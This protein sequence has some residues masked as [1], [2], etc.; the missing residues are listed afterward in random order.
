MAFGAIRGIMWKKWKKSK[1]SE[2]H[3]HATVAPMPGTHALEV[4]DQAVIGS[5][6]SIKG[7]LIGEEDLSIEGRLE[8]K[9]ELWHHRLTIEKS[10]RI[11]G[12]IHGKVIT[13][14][15]VVEGNLYAEEQLI[16]CQSA[17]IRGNLVSP[18]VAIEDGADFKGSIDMGLKEKPTTPLPPDRGFGRM[19]TRDLRIGSSDKA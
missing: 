7:D 17:T 5:T 6:I 13:V 4:K 2:F 19:V 18:R 9:I 16:V 14:E 15:G 11:K 8:G 3:P 12:D 1:P 10:G